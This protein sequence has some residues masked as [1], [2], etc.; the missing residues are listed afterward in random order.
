[1]RLLL[2]DPT[3]KSEIRST[4]SETIFKFKIINSKQLHFCHTR[5]CR[6]SSKEFSSAI[7]EADGAES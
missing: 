5:E 4:K 1:M 2:P 3:Y 6:V 7:T